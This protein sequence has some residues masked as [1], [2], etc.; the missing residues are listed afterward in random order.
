MVRVHNE[1]LL[2]RIRVVHTQS[3]RLYGSPRITAVLWEQGLRCGKTRVARLMKASC[4]RGE[5]KK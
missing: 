4:L 1:M 5:V 2:G 3:R